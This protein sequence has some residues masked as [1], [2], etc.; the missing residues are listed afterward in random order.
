MTTFAAPGSPKAFV[1]PRG[2]MCSLV[3]P[4]ARAPDAVMDEFKS[5]TIPLH[6][7]APSTAWAH[8]ANKRLGGHGPLRYFLPT[9]DD[10]R[11]GLCAAIFE[12]VR[13]HDA[14]PAT[15]VRVQSCRLSKDE[16]IDN[17]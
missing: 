12:D 17:G 6:Q 15:V 8:V 10:G 4:V 11:F 1:E 16:I 7:G 9:S 3:Y 5:A 14:T 13:L 2:G